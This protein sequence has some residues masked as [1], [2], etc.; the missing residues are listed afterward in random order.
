MNEYRTELAGWMAGLEGGSPFN[1]HQTGSQV[2]ADRR[3]TLRRDLLNL[4]RMGRGDTIGVQ[5]GR[6]LLAVLEKALE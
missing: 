6:D 5:A 3:R 2:L 1:R 4:E